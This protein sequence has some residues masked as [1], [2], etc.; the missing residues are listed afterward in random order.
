MTAQER[1][2]LDAI[3]RP[4]YTGENRCMACTLLNVVLAIVLGGLLALVAPGIGVAVFV[5]A[6]ASIYLRGYLVPGTPR[7]TKR[8]LPDRVLAAFD[9]HEPVDS[10]DESFETLAELER[11]REQS[12]DPEAFLLDVGAIEPC[13]DDTDVCLTDGFATAV[14]ER[15][16]E[17]P[18]LETL[19]KTMAELFETERAAVT[20]LDRSYPAF[21]VGSRVRKWPSEAALMLDLAIHEAL[22]DRTEEWETV[23]KEQ[24]IRM[25]Q[26]LRSFHETCPLCGGELAFEEEIVESCCTSHAVVAFGCTDCE[27]RIL[28]LDPTTL[29]DGARNKGIS[30]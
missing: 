20:H 11:E 13:E 26:S 1:S 14:R 27:A 16:L 5:V 18:G 25:L 4:E 2:P 17:D 10:G 7:L 24:R 28:E 22:A 23:P 21:E 6:L 9:G 12:V 19:S 3:R 8:Y 29:E 30:A 15:L